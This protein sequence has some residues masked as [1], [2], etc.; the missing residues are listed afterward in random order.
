[1]QT[2]LVIDD[3]RATRMILEQ[4]LRAIGFDVCQAANGREALEV[5][6]RMP[7]LSL[8]VVD[9]NMPEMNGL[10]FVKAFRGNP[11]NASV[12]ILMVTTETDVEHITLALEAGANEYMMKPFSED[13]MAGKLMLLGIQGSDQ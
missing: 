13:V 3:S 6:Q 4:Q 10:E 9:W 2:A 11:R 12:P 7:Q 1:M 8:A 5:V